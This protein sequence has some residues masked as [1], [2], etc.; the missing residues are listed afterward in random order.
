MKTRHDR[1][2]LTALGLHRE[3][4]G[5]TFT[6]AE[7]A[8]L[9]EL[10]PYLQMVEATSDEIRRLQGKHAVTSAFFEELHSGVAYL[11][12]HGRISATNAAFT[13]GLDTG[14]FLSITASGQLLARARQGQAGLDRAIAGAVTGEIQAVPLRSA[15]G[16]IRIL[17]IV[18]LSIDH[19][20]RSSSAD[21][22]I[23]FLQDLQTSHRSKTVLHSSFGLT[24]READI[25]LLIATNHSV[26]EIADKLQLA[27]PTVR[28][29]LR[30]IFAKTETRRQSEVATLILKL[31]G[32][33]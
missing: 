21:I 5:R 16:D 7:R 15:A 10:V 11:D 22:A 20:L 29:H 23:L 3:E 33:I 18:P 9:E 14:D 8:A 13:I 26:R 32:E 25:A 30:S 12:R 19:P 31:I 17:R 2:T 27:V 4:V 24:R 1:E 28:V 6:S